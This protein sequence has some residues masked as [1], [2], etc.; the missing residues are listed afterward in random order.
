MKIGKIS[1]LV[2]NGNLATEDVACIVVPEFKDCASYGGVGAAIYACGMS[3]GL[4]TYDKAVQQKPLNY[5]DVL[6]TDSGK[7]NIKLAHVATAGATKD[8][9]FEAVFK[10]VVRVLMEA[11]KLNLPTIAVPEIGTGII[12]SL[13]QEQSAKAIFAAVYQFGKLYPN[14]KVKEV[15]LVIYR[16]SILPAEKILSE[17]SFEYQNEVGEKEFNFAEWAIEMQSMLG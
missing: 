10:A 11:D 13:T 12:G 14:A 6:I 17:Q 9:Q 8:K 1:I 7:D 15:R 2:K 16:S 5:G 3:K 4:D